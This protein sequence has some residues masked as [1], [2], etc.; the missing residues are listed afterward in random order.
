[1]NRAKVVDGH[2]VATHL[3]TVG[4]LNDGR[5]V[6]GYHQLPATVLTAEGWFPVVD[7]GPPP[8]NPDTHRARRTSHIYDPQ[9]DTVTV[10]YDIVE[11]PQPLPEPAPDGHHDP[12]IGAPDA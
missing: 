4:T 3:P 12:Q 5:A 10:V 1:M 9:S 11:R 7:D 8:H 6:S 2:I